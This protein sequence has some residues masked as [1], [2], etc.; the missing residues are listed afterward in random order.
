MKQNNEVTISKKDAIRELWYRG[1]LSYKLHPSQKKMMD[2]YL[3]QQK[4]ITVIVCSRRFG[5]SFALCMLAVETCLKTS[6]AIVK[7]VCPKKNMVKTILQPIMRDILI[8]CPPEIKPEFKYN[9]YVYAFPNGSQIQM[10]GT[11]NGNHE[12]LRGSKCDLWII[13]EA[14]FCDELSY[15]VKTI[16]APTTDTTGG[17]GILASTP[18]KSADHEFISDFYRPYEEKN[19]L[20]KYTVYDNSLLTPIKIQEIIDRYPLKEKD[21]EFLREY[22]CEARN[23]GDMSIVPEFTLELKKLVVKEVERPPFY[24]AY[25]SMDIGGRD[26]TVVLFGYYDFINARTVIEDELVFGR[27]QINGQLEEFRIDTFAAQIIRKEQ[28]L[29]THKMSGEFKSPYLRIA[30]NNNII[31][32]SDLTYRHNLPFI[33]TRK[34][35]REAA[36]N[37]MRVK[38]GEEKILIHPRCTTLIYQLENGTWAKN[39]KDFSRSQTQGHWDAIP[40]LMYLMRN[41][42]ENRNPYPPGYG[43]RGQD[44]Y[45]APN[46]EK[47]HTASQ[48][49]WINI[50]KTRKSI[51]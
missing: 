9:E 7:Y 36:L 43:A 2:T 25:V 8:D 26:L 13:D 44:S 46:Q 31:L 37:T 32:L 48:Q 20:I 12:N 10:A 14:G 51:K 1:N 38:L 15:V 17:R 5:K 49:A 19:E 11:D 50:F 28:A 21:P 45:F 4:E 34:D 33:P 24:D 27:K 35:N 41:I 22:M 6:N 30:D 42:Q 39:K 29:W 16:L 40:A 23:S 3:S 47:P 18:S